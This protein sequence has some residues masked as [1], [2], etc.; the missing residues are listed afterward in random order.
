MAFATFSSG[1]PPGCVSSR[2]FPA[3]AA[4]TRP[5]TLCASRLAGAIFSACSAVAMASDIRLCRK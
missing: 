4:Y 3:T 2:P 1:F 5:S